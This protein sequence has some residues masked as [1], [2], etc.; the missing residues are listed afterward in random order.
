MR[1][2]AL[3]APL[4]LFWYTDVN[5]IKLIRNVYFQ[6]REIARAVE[7][8]DEQTKKTI[9]NLHGQGVPKH[10]IAHRISYAIKDKARAHKII[11]GVTAEAKKRD[12]KKLRDEAMANKRKL[13]EKKNLIKKQQK[14]NKRK[15]SMSRDL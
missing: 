14:A 6:A 4:R 13:M 1:S 3:P 12:P 11:D 7:N 10:D 5:I 9:I 8:L 2:F 15:R